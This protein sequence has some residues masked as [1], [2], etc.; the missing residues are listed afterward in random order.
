MKKQIRPSLLILLGA[1]LLLSITWL[2]FANSTMKGNYEEV[3]FGE[4]SFMV[5]YPNKTMT[6]GKII[7]G[8]TR[9]DVCQSGYAKKVRSDLTKTKK[10][11]IYRNYNVPYDTSKYQIDHLV[12]ISI[13]G[14]NDVENLWP[15]PIVHNAGYLE[16]QQ[17]AQ[18]LHEK[19]CNGSI[20]IEEAQRLMLKDWHQGWHMLQHEKG[21]E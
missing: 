12:P 18:W 17:V 9:Q 11:M 10:Q 16:K 2:A 15:Q 14:S 20:Q 19:V 6:P 7:P 5:A 3:G 21:K 13:G 8:V 4:K 1:T